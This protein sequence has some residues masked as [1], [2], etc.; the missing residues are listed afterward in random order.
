MYA[1]VL[2]YLSLYIY[3]YMYVYIKEYLARVGRGTLQKG[4]M[5]VGYPKVFIK[6]KVHIYIYIERER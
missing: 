6:L 4:S 3:I 2:S 1:Y 5:E